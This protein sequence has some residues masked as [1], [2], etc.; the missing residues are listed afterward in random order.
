MKNVL[1]KGEQTT[2][3]TNIRKLT[4]TTVQK[5]FSIR[6]HLKDIAEKPT[7]PF[8]NRPFLLGFKNG[9]LDLSMIAEKHEDGTPVYEHNDA[10]RPYE[11]SDFITMNT[12]YDFEQYDYENQPEIVDELNEFFLS[13]MPK[14]EHGILLYQCLAS[15][16]DGLLY[17]RFFM[18]NGQGGNGKGSIF[19][20]MSLV[21]GSYFKKANNEL[22]KGFGKANQASEDMMDLKGIR[23]LIFEEIGDEIDN[24]T[25]KRLTGGGELTGRRL[26]KGNES[27][28]LN[29]TII[30]SF[31][32]KP[33]LKYKPEGN[34]ELR[35]LIDMFF[36]RNFTDKP[37]KVGKKEMVDNMEIEWCKS[38]PKYTTK[39]WG[40]KIRNGLLSMLLNVYNKYSNGE[41]G[42]KFDVPLDIQ[43]RVEDF[44][45]AQNIFNS[46]F[47]TIYEQVDN[48]KCV[49]K[50]CDIWEN[51]QY[52][53]EYKELPYKD[54]RRYNRKYFDEW[55]EKRA[56]VSA[57]QGNVK[58]IKGYKRIDKYD[59]DDIKTDT[60]TII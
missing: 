39:Q 18:F 9:V 58:V 26:F 4:G 43:R 55:V 6:C 7:E 10:F 45:D 5:L 28:T 56:S 57:G 3:L 31:N 20:L 24:N 29:S 59:D 14:E 53:S 25:M 60:E 48:D 19:E 41:E 50:L 1:Q 51:I 32:A 37:D 42:I 52:N 17:Q 23:M 16:L 30:A 21:L 8:N 11:Y 22:L 2:H 46:I 12:G 15:C 34:S 54:K 44:L 49:V 13:V 47:N 38:N 27:F 40:L 35:R 33:K 36:C